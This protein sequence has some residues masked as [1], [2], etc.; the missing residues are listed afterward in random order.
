VT[1]FPEGI[2]PNFAFLQKF[3]DTAILAKGLP[4]LNPMISRQLSKIFNSIANLT[5]WQLYV[6]FKHCE[7][8][9]YGLAIEDGKPE[10]FSRLYG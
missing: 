4:L 5:G 9:I 7:G 3:R 10:A 6:T 8:Y 1:T 2:W